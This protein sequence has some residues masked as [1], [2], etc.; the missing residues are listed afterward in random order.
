MNRCLP[1]LAALSL[2]LSGCDGRAASPPGGAPVVPAETLAS[3]AARQRGRELYLHHCALCHGARA[4]G[5]GVRRSLSSRPQDFT[6]PAW[7]A[8]A[9]PAEVFRVIREGRRRTAMAGWPSLDDEQTWQLVAY[10]LSV[11][12]GG[13]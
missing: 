5:E 4:D 1:A 9:S 2:A 7:R 12:E 6:N 10:L 3:A 11:S 13:R 8:A